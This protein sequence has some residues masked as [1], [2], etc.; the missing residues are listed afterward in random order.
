MAKPTIDLFIG[1]RVIGIT[2]GDEPWEWGIMLESGVEVRNKDERETMRPMFLVE[3]H[4]VLQT[5][6]QSSLDTTLHFR[7]YDGLMENVSFKPT[8][9]TICDPKYGDEVYPQ[10]PVEL[11]EMGITANEGKAGVSPE[12]ENPDEW[13]KEELRRRESARQRHEQQATEFLA[14]EGDG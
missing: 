9:Y 10:W 6:S 2:H 7:K 14:E 11:D 4:C 3:Q 13:R 12:P 5:I 8:A 1:E